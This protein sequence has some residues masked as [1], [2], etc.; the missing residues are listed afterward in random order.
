M[1]KEIPIFFSIDDSYAPYLAVALNSAIKNCSPDRKYK[2]IVLYKDLSEENRKRLS[3]FKTDNFDIQFE[4]MGTGLETITDRMSNRLRC[5]YFTLTIYFRLFIPA[6][7]PQYDKAIYIDSD[8]VL[9][10]DLAELFDTD[11]GENYIGACN[12]LS[13]LDVPPL[14]E[15][16]EKA[17]GVAKEQYINSGVLLMNLKL[18]REK[19]LDKHFLSLLNKYHFDSVAPDQDYLNALCNGKIYYLS[20]VWDAMPN[21]NRPELEDA[22][23]IHYNLFSKPW[24][25]DDIQYGEY[26]WEYAKDSGYIDKIKEFKNS[27]SDSQK[28]ADS[29]CLDLLIDRGLQIANSDVTFKKMYD[30]GVKIRL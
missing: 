22:R 9:K 6:M 23:L 26:F 25:Y 11:I 18:L 3:V 21:D 13:V 7:F 24:C 27:Y 16:M 20:E 2:A 30:S 12:D 29:K 1:N 15:Y 8:I 10:G 28:E 19:E 4:S 5:D 14:C 17:V